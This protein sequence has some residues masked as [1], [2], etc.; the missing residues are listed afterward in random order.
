MRVHIEVEK[1]SNLK[2][3]FIFSDKENGSIPASGTMNIKGLREKSHASPYFFA[4]QKPI[5]TPQ[6]ATAGHFVGVTFMP[7]CIRMYCSVMP[8]VVCPG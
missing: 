2:I 4:P 8:T 3:S 6:F 7:L 1:F 5:S